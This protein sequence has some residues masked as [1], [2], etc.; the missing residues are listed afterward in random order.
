MITATPI[1]ESVSTTVARVSAARAANR[2]ADAVNNALPPGATAALH[3]LISAA[4]DAWIE[5]GRCLERDDAAE[6]L[7]SPLAAPTRHDTDETR[8][9]TRPAGGRVLGA[10]T[11]RV[12]GGTR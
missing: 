10:A 3:L 6:R 1:P 11:G 5:L 12:D 7:L 9:R 2:V 8:L 4:R